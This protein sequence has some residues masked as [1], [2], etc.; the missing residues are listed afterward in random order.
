MVH[1]FLRSGFVYVMAQQC[2][3]HGEVQI[4]ALPFGPMWREDFSGR[5]NVTDARLLHPGGGRV[6]YLGEKFRDANTTEAREID[7]AALLTGG[8]GILLRKDLDF[9]L[10]QFRCPC[11]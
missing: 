10:P 4:V 1:Q 9:R 8:Q 6:F 3:Q 2:S 11:G 7:T 5:L